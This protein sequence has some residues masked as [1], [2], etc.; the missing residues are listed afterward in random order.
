VRARAF[1]KKIKESL[2]SGLE[3]EPQNLK[4][5]SPIYFLPYRAKKGCKVVDFELILGLGG[6]ENA[7]N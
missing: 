3:S 5:G 2:E 7:K 4:K 1:C 6:Q